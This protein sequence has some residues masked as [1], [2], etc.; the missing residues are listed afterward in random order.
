MRI[1]VL[2]TGNV[3]ST[4]GRRWAKNGHEIIF[5]AR[6]P[7][8]GKVRS[9]L[10]SIGGSARATSVKEAV[11]ASDVVVLTI[12]WDATQDVIRE[13]GSLDG[14]IVIDCT[15]PLAEG[16]SGL[17]VGLTTSAG[18]K[19]A[20]WARGARVVK[21]FNTTGAKNMA[22]PQYGSQRVTM[23]I[24]GDD[25]EARKAVAELAAQLGFEVCETGPLYHARY[26]EPMAMLW[27]DMA[28]KQ[29]F[30]TD[31]AFKIIKR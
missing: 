21:A 3:G 4:L 1:A 29:G 10:S 11:A 12:P 13:A 16:L 27:I 5:G 9:L 24:C 26:L 22:D 8:S 19:V 7:E 28:V 23:F 20:E 6:D 31:F 15:N 2:G 30:G 25:A 17:S 18:E 14:K